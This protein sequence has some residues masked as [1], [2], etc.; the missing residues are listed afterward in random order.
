MFK[1]IL[2]PLDR[3]D[4]AEQ[5][6]GRAAEIA[7]ASDGELDL[8]LVHQPFAIG[9]FDDAPWASQTW[10]DDHSYVETIVTELA[11]S[12]RIRATHA[13][14]KGDPVEMICRRAEDIGAD[15]IVMTSHGRTGLS[16]AWLGSVADGVL[17]ESGVPVLLLRPIQG[18]GRVG[19]ASQLFNHLL[20]PI[21]GSSASASIIPAAVQLAALTGA[22]VTLFRVVRP[23]PLIIAEFG[24]PITAPPIVPD[25]DLTRKVEAEARQ[26]VVDLAARSSE[27]GVHVDA[28]VVVDDHVAQAILAFANTENIDAIAMTTHGRGA[29]RLLVGS[30]ADKVLRASG[31][32]M[33]LKRPMS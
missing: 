5:A 25:I 20:V 23:V 7:R 11:S 2:V 10:K 16:R 8:T 3:S 22:R 1:T 31:L 29:S 24:V 32:P 4:L 21:D 13:I 17:R 28:Q 15:L 30:I 27:H 9:G 33:L 18:Q 14:I 6:L 12:A 26:Q 19:A